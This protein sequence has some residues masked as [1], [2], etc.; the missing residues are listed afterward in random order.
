MQSQGS[1][2]SGASALFVEGGVEPVAAE[3]GGGGGFGGDVGVAEVVGEGERGG[4]G[5]G[6]ERAGGQGKIELGADI[7]GGGGGE[8]GER[9]KDAEGECAIHGGGRAVG[10][11]ATTPKLDVRSSLRGNRSGWCGRR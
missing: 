5:A 4:G 7:R 6:G 1:F 10:A 9:E 11:V 8:G 2:T 3:G